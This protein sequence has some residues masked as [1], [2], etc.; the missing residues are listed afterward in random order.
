MSILINVTLEDIKSG[1]ARSCE[2][3]PIALAAQRASSNYSSDLHNRVLVSGN[4]I[5][6]FR[7]NR[8]PI[9]VEAQCFISTFDS[10]DPV[11]PF[12]F[13]LHPEDRMSS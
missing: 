6:L 3:C 2:A 13:T 9:P 8:Y 12:S 5:R 10:D 11:E 7:D 4:Q 1:E